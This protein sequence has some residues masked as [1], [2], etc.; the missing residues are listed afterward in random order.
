MSPY[1]SAYNVINT[2]NATI[3]CLSTLSSRNRFLVEALGPGRC[4]SLLASRR[5]GSP[6]LRSNPGR[7]GPYMTLTG[8]PTRSSLRT[9][10]FFT[11][12]ATLIS[13]LSANSSRRR[14]ARL[15]A[16]ILQFSPGIQNETPR[17]HPLG[18]HLR[19]LGLRRSTYPLITS[20]YNVGASWNN[21]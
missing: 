2:Y 12:R 11:S 21:D 18:A 14:L 19:F 6:D 9:S 16:L 15:S 5:H 20:V 4:L 3:A 8:Q 17:N 13:W 1:S 10:A 7:L